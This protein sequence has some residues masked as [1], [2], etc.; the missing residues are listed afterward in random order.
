MRRCSGLLLLAAA[1]IAVPSSA[2]GD[3]LVINFRPV[4]QYVH[5][6]FYALGGATEYNPAS[7]DWTAEFGLGI[8]D[9]DE[10]ELL[11]LILANAA[12]PNH[13]AIHAAFENNR[14]KIRTACGTTLMNLTIQSGATYGLDAI[15]GAYLTMGEWEN[16]NTVMVGVNG[17]MGSKVTW[18]G[19]V[20]ENDALKAN[21]TLTCNV[22]LGV[23]GDADLDTVK[24]GNEWWAAA[25]ACRSRR[26]HGPAASIRSCSIRR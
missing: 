21:Y 16:V 14:T 24:N 19:A 7:A 20:G 4:M 5:E 2:F 8:L 11:G 22:F 1:L 3:A 17:Q 18:E 13:D 25:P 23:C 10:F 15:L 6:Q 26:R 9:I 12:A